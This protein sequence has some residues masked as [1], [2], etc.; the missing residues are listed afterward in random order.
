LKLL[1]KSLEIFCILSSLICLFHDVVTGIFHWPTCSGGTAT[2]G[3][4]QHLTEMSTRYISW[5]RGGGGKGG[6]CVGLT[7]LPPSLADCLEVLVVWTSWSLKKMYRDSFTFNCLSEKSVSINNTFLLNKESPRTNTY[8]EIQVCWWVLSPT[9]KETSYS[10]RRF[11]VSYTL[12]ITII[13]GILVLFIRIYKKTR[14]KRNILNIKQNK[15][16]SRL[17]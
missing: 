10:D 4:T 15:S 16:R 13:G 1:R 2:L 9:R 5:G 11:W 17:G 7:T 3:S 6:P 14:I 12:F 8:N